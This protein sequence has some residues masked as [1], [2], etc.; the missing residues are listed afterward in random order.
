VTSM[1]LH[2]SFSNRRAYLNAIEA[3]QSGARRD[4]ENGAGPSGTH[5][6]D[7]D[8]DGDNGNEDLDDENDLTKEDDEDQFVDSDDD[9]GD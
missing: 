6:S 2:R 7:D 4:D 3:K 8:N 5:H 9:N 1:Y